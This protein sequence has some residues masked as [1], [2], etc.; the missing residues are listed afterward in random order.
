MKQPVQSYVDCI[1]TPE[2]FTK[3]ITE[4]AACY[5]GHHVFK[6]KWSVDNTCVVLES[7]DERI[8]WNIYFDDTNN[9]LDGSGHTL[10]KNT[11]DSEWHTFSRRGIEDSFYLYGRDYS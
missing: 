11:P 4:G 3:T 2:G 6:D 10:F 1:P 5:D 8:V 7:S 9:R